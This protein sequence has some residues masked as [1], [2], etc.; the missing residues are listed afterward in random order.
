MTGPGPARYSDAA[1][2]DAWHKNAAP[3]TDTVR[4]QAIESRRLVTDHAIVETALRHAPHS[5]LDLGC[6]EGWLTRA[7]VARGV[8]THGVDA[9]PAL[10]DAARLA[11]PG[12]PAERYA[13]LSYE[14]I[15]D[16][17]LNARFDRVLC[18][19]SLLGFEAVDR[20]IGA[21]PTLLTPHGALIVQTLH[22][23]LVAGDAPYR[24]GWRDGSWAGCEGTF[25]EPAPWY[26]R[27]LGSWL[28]LLRASG[29]E[30]R[31]LAEPLH[32]HSGRP[33]SLI[34]VVTAAAIR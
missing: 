21:I 27:T 8:R 24:D 17:A 6:G 12:A 13:C 29:L 9:I 18:N 31:E 26:F 14:A 19:F 22:P 10:I 4:A 2:L 25:G 20:L 5:A 15:A 11:D 16:G 32:P 7:L 34:L 28:A 3:W 30:L 23:L 1:V 33:A